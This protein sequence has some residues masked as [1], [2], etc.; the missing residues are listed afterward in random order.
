MAGGS[1]RPIDIA[2]PA[3]EWITER[4]WSEIL[5][6]ESLEEFKGFAQN[7]YKNIQDFKKIFDSSEPERLVK[8]LRA[9]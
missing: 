3:P 5:T 8:L 1:L 4:I 9:Y 2:N 7:F 6:L